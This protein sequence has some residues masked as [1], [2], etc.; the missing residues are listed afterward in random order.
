M[1]NLLEEDCD[2]S[3]PDL[4]SQGYLW[5][6]QPL[7][8]SGFANT[9]GHSRSTR[10][11]SA[12]KELLLSASFGGFLHS[13][14]SPKLAAQELSGIKALKQYVFNFTGILHEAGPC[15]IH[16]RL[17]NSIGAPEDRVLGSIDVRIYRVKTLTTL[18]DCATRHPLRGRLM[19]SSID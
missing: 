8:L 3:I 14:E 12:C 15:E 17:S 19:R 10:F 1:R 16:E 2:H 5:F 4:F 13:R 11:P 18:C 6:L 7:V 9:L